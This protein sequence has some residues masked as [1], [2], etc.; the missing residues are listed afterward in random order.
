[1]RLIA[2]DGVKEHIHS[3]DSFV[4]DKTTVTTNDDS[5]IE[6]IPTDQVEFT[7]SEELLISKMEEIIQ[8]FLD[9]L[10]VTGGDLDP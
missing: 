8:L 6:P 2:I 5:E 9:L 7:T 10:Q 4:D 1:M 3:G